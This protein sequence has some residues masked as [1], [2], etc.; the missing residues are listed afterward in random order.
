MKLNRINIE[1]NNIQLIK[2]DIKYDN[3]PIFAT[4]KYLKSKSNKYGWFLTDD[5]ILPFTIDKKLIFKR[6]IFTT[7]TIYLNK[8]LTE[9]EEKEFLNNVVSYCKKN[10]I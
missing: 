1:K 9:I 4:E 8:N 3:L 10:N 6:L 5:F 7:E 2:K